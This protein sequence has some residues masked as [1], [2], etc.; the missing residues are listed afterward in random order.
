MDW[1]RED[2]CLGLALP[3]A[4]DRCTSFLQGEPISPD[5]HDAG[6][7]HADWCSTEIDP[8]SPPIFY[9]QSH[10][11]PFDSLN[12]TFASND[13]NSA[14]VPDDLERLQG[15]LP[16][17]DQLDY[18]QPEN[19][20]M[21]LPAWG[22]PEVNHD[23]DVDNWFFQYPS[24]PNLDEPSAML[25]QDIISDDP[26]ELLDIGNSLPLYASEAII[27]SQD[28]PG[29]VQHKELTSMLA[30]KLHPSTDNVDVA[31]S[32]SVRHSTG[33]AW[34]PVVPTICTHVTEATK[35]AGQTAVRPQSEGQMQTQLATLTRNLARALKEPTSE[36]WDRLRPIIWA[37][38][39]KHTIVNVQDILRDKHR[40]R[41]RRVSSL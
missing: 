23:T 26:S 13:V 17:L 39:R 24:Q 5:F 30:P 11:R 28:V 41:T 35:P 8:H 38:T 18:A 1:R 33:E 9:R 2:E 29:S 16:D 21:P 36:D 20:A 37:L 10:S 6:L 27:S 3:Q 7:P 34:A 31:E 15:T 32:Q 14:F 40:M 19:S 4:E 12:S 25:L 22:F